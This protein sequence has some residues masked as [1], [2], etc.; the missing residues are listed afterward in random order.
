[1]RDHN[2]RVQPAGSAQ[3]NAFQHVFR[4]AARGAYYM[5]AAVMD[6]VI[7]QH[8]GKRRICRARKEIQAAV[9]AQYGAGLFHNSAHGRH[10]QHIVKT[11][12]RQ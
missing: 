5:R 1:M 7:V 2:R 11:A 12:V 8:C 3:A 10:D 4:I 9:P 6:I